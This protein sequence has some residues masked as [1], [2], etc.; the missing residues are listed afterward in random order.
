MAQG[1]QAAA[2]PRPGPALDRVLELVDLVVQVVDEVEVALRDVVD[3][4]V[5]DHP[6]GVVVADRFAHRPWGRTGG[7]P[8]GSS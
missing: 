3:E 6:G 7:G 8:P 1:R 4:L 5:G 2:D